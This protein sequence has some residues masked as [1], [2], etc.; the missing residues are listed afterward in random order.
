MEVLD[1]RS[2]IRR[3]YVLLIFSFISC[4][5]SMIWLTYSPIPDCTE[6]YYGISQNQVNTLLNWGPIFFILVTPPLI[7]LIRGRRHIFKPLIRLAAT[8]LFLATSLRLAPIWL[9]WEPAESVTML[10]VHMGQ[11]VAACV[12]PLV[13]A[14]PSSLRYV[15]Y[16]YI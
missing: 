7:A 2:D 10:F 13:M 15:C 11:I 1:I 12:G 6:A 4:I 8:M 9:G 5:Q 3:W 16:I 14:T